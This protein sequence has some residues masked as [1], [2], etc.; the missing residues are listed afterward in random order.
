MYNRSLIFH[1]S[2]ESKPGP[3]VGANVTANPQ[4]KWMVSSWML[5]LPL[6]KT[7]LETSH[8]AYVPDKTG[9]SSIVLDI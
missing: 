8:D 2:E 5:V 3:G 9:K 6:Q 4:V 7:L 1:N